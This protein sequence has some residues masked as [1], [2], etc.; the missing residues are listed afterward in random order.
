M[1]S[2]RKRWALLLAAAACAALFCF[3]HPVPALGEEED[4]ATQ[5][6]AGPESSGSQDVSGEAEETPPAPEAEPVSLDVVNKTGFSPISVKVVRVTKA[7]ASGGKKKRGKKAAPREIK[8][9]AA[10]GKIVLNKA[11]SFQL[12]AEGD[13]VIYI[14]YQDGGATHYA[15]GT[16]HHLEGG[17]DYRLTLGPVQGTAISSVPKSEFDQLK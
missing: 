5:D 14:S 9:V 6:A 1:D 12:S 15:K 8:K 10:S 11:V 13:Y 16:V 7:A 4:A 2:L 17:G 3:A